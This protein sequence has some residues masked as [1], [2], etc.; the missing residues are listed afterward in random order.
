MAHRLE[1]LPIY[2]RASAF[3]TA[4]TAILERPAFG[5]NRDLRDQIDDANDSILANMSEG[6]EQ[7]TDA[8]L[9][10][11]LYHAKASAA[12]VVSHLRAAARKHIIT[13]ADLSRVEPMGEELG[14]ML[15][16]WIKYLDTSG[17]K[18]RGRHRTSLDS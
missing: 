16:G 18:N 9:A 15:G 12:E 1:E 10:K 6:F 5:R 8:G 11:F 14:R 7:P 2:S 17:F 3:C 4:V 13:P